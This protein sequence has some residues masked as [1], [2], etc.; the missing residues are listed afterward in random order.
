M[1]AGSNIRK[2]NCGRPAGL[3]LFVLFLIFMQ[4]AAPDTGDILVKGAGNTTNI[5]IG[6]FDIISS[7]N[8]TNA[9][10]D[11]FAGANNYRPY[12]EITDYWAGLYDDN[13]HF[14][15]I[16]AKNARKTKWNRQLNENIS[17]SNNNRVI[18]PVSR[19]H[20]LWEHRQAPS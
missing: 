16:G 17:I 1:D 4:M 19:I 20:V 15:K 6:D 10:T 3:L 2:N 12:S 5:D 9:E 11:S 7:E 8:E 18:I 14:A 13:S